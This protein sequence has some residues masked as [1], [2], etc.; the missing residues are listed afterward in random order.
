MIKKIS[1][2]LSCTLLLANSAWAA[3]FSLSPEEREKIIER[4]LDRC[5]G[6]RRWRP[7]SNEEYCKNMAQPWTGK[8]PLHIAIE[9]GY[10]AEIRTFAAQGYDLNTANRWGETFLH[11]AAE[12]RKSE[13]FDLLIELGAN[14]YVGDKKG[15]LAWPE[16]QMVLAAQVGDLEVMQQLYAPGASLEAYMWNFHNKVGLSVLHLLVL[17]RNYEALRWACTELRRKFKSL[18]P[19]CGVGYEK[20]TP[21]YYAEYLH[22]E[23]AQEILRD[24]KAHVRYGQQEVRENELEDDH[25][26]LPPHEKFALGSSVKA[27]ES[28]PGGISYNSSSNDGCCIQ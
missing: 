5:E 4:E 21:L 2:V 14:R 10:L 24:F 9:K 6:P 17:S 11:D 13:V 25:A 1:T 12:L 23:Q 28:V 27:L 26:Q 8:T 19:T 22:D 16:R 3:T 18:N 15:R 20:W 7:W